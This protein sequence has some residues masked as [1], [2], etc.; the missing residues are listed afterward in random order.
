MSDMYSEVSDLI[1]KVGQMNNTV[2][3]TNTSVQQTAKDLNTQFQ[4]SCKKNLDIFQSLST[5]NAKIME[6]AGKELKRCTR[7]FNTHYLCVCMAGLLAG[8]LFT[9]IANY[10]MNKD[11]LSRELQALD[12][13]SSANELVAKYSKYE[14]YEKYE[15]FLKVL[16]EIDQKDDKAIEVAFHQN[17]I[18]G[19]IKDSKEDVIQ[20]LVKKEYTTVCETTGTECYLTD[21]EGN[22][23]KQQFYRTG[24]SK[25]SVF[26]TLKK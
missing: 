18:E 7:I 8:V 10:Y 2:Q 11:A 13:Q 26:I 22:K 25:D 21:S 9:Q 12:T 3:E 4:S 24:T 17:M 14:K 23:L 16:H 15:D 1:N 5:Q 20:L 19:K 6:D